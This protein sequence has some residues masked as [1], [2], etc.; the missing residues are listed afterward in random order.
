MHYAWVVAFTGT[1]VLLLAQGFGR[2]SY[3][4]ILPPMK[5]GLNLS[6]TQ[7]GLIGTA[8]FVGYLSLAL[9]GG[10]LAVRF[11]PR[12]T[13]F[14]SMIVMGITLFFTGLAGSFS[15]AFLLRLGT[16]MGNGGVVVPVMGLTAA[17]FSAD[18]RGLAAGI[19][20]AGTGLGLS[21]AGLLLPRFM[22]EFG[23]DGWRYAWFLLGGSVFVFSFLCFALL[24]DHP[25]EKGTYQYGG[26]AEPS[27][28]R[29]DV[30]FFSAWSDIV[31]ESEIWRL[32]TVYFMYGVSYIIY[33]TFFVAYMVSEAGLT[34]QSA[35]EVFALL[36]L[37]SILS[38][39]V[40]G[41][42]SDVLGRRYGLMLAYVV[43]AISYLVLALWRSTPG[44]YVSAI[45]FGVCMSSVPTIMAAAAGDS[46]GGKLAPAALGMITL[47]FGIGQS[48]GP[49][50]AGWIKDATGTFAW[51]FMLSAGVSLLGAAGSL[52][53][54]RKT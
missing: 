53:L 29:T 28:R 35:G 27:E 3:S 12:R 30:S 21:A 36:G 13:I 14:V 39:V 48:I 25:R 46:V 38:G 8:N 47:L 49:T 42:V 17:W 19:L 20:T 4:V 32:G 23:P 16:G 11:G 51:A 52:T 1:L 6:Y 24:R 26:K 41:W 37:C 22:A 7:V 10:F 40:W 18:K 54:K 31:R 50:L 33:I 44:A 15:H 2:M 43:L 5:E 45:V 9:L 34:R